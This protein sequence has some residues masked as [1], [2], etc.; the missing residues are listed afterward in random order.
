[1]RLSKGVKTVRW[2]NNL[3]IFTEAELNLLPDGCE[4]VSIGGDKVIKGK[5]PIDTDTRYGHIAFGVI[6]PK[7][8]PEAEL[9][10]TF[11]LKGF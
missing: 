9:F 4:L 7:N 6:D 10:A 3:W 11:V 8:H 5:D 1:M 2:G